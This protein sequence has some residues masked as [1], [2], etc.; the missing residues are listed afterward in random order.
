MW[1]GTRRAQQEKHHF[2]TGTAT[3]SVLMA[4]GEMGG[5]CGGLLCQG[6][7]GLVWTIIHSMTLAGYAGVLPDVL[8]SSL[9]CWSPA[10]CAGALPENHS[11]TSQTRALG[12]HLEHPAGRVPL[13]QIPALPSSIPVLGEHQGGQE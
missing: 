5:N 11:S 7:A 13:S 12:G 1:D 8:G 6:S 10:R 9:M 2:E 4:T 3:C